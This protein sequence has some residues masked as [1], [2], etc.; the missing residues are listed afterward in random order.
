M[1]KAPCCPHKQDLL[2]L[3]ILEHVN[4]S[5]RLTNRTL[6]AKLGCQIKLTHSILTKMVEKGLLQ[7]VKI[8]TRR[9]DYF[10]TPQ[11][12]AEKTRLTCEFFSFSMRFYQE[13]RRRSAQ[14]C[15]DLAESGRKD[16]AF[17]GDSELA[18]IVYLGVREWGLNLIEVYGQSRSQFMGV[19]VRDPKQ[20][21]ATKANAVIVC[22]Y[23]K[24]MPMLKQYL[25]SDIPKPDNVRWIFND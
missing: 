13:A 15:R 20:L 1:D 19:E 10:L 7:V 5:C 18:E 22:E 23:D 21:P 11:G 4:G 16:V 12:I 2:A 6:T 8:H 9:W 14:V 17:L 25:P 24:A 3:E